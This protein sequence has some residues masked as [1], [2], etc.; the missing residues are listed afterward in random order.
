MQ[1]DSIAMLGSLADTALDLDRQPRRRCSACASR[2]MPADHDHRF[3]HGK[4]EA[5]V[6]LAQVVIITVSAIGIAWRA[7]ERLLHGAQTAG[8]GLGIGVSLVAIA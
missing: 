4:A 6:A 8:D 2:R 7:V 1:T 5:L 3:G